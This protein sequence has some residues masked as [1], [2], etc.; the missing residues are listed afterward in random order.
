MAT[1]DQRR[2][3]TRASLVEAARTLMRCD[4]VTGTTTRAILEAAQVSRGAMY[5]HFTSLEDLIAAVYEDEAQSAIK[6]AV[7]HH[8]PGDSP[9]GD[10]LGVCL[11]WLD[12]LAKPQVARILAVEGPSA[13]GWQRC[14]DIEAK[15]SLVPMI[16]WLDAAS[17]KGEID[18]AS[19]DLVARILNAALTEAALSIIHSPKKKLARSEAV[20]TFQQI[21]NGLRTGAN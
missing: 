13:L 14:R 21:V 17:R 15:H 18:I 11:A 1:Q 10:L 19:S 7:R 20:N 4:G 2:Q 12:E 3:A 16:A 6:R 9:I 5:H 8:P